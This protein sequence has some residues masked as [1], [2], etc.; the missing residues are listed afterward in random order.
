MLTTVKLHGALAIAA[1]AAEWLLDVM[2]PGEALRAIECQTGKL[3]A[4]LLEKDEEGIRYRVLVEGADCAAKEEVLKTPIRHYE[5]IEFIP[6]PAGAAGLWETIAG[7]VLIVVGTIMMFYPMTAAFGPSVIIAGIGLLASGTI[8]MFFG[9]KPPVIPH[10]PKDRQQEDQAVSYHFNGPTNTVGQGGAVPLLYGRMTVGGAT[11]SSG[12]RTVST[13]LEGDD[14]EGDDE[15]EAKTAAV[16]GVTAGLFDRVEKG[17]GDKVKAA[18][19]QM[20]DNDN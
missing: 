19:E 10:S 15:Q 2:T 12:I 11:I 13:K 9:P 20:N 3:F 16:L 14:Q 17:S 1:G 7:V 4:H 5:S 6:V 8:Q 18:Q